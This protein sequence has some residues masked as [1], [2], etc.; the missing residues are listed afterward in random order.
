MCLLGFTY[1][2]GRRL[3]R[4]SR[5][6]LFIFLHLIKVEAQISSENGV[7]DFHKISPSVSIRQTK[8]RAEDEYV[9]T[10]FQS[11]M[12]IEHIEKHKALA[13]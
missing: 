12:R 7:G 6:R 13:T 8:S 10:R 3:Y 1:V 2:C 9:E 11:C 4:Q 5:L